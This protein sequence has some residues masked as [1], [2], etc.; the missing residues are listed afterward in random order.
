MLLLRVELPNVPG[1]LGRL[2]SAIGAAGGDIEAIEIVEKRLDGTDVET[3]HAMT[4]HKSQGSQAAEVTVL[5][6]PDDSRLLTRELLYT[7]LTRAEQKV[8]LV[9]TPDAVRLAVARPAQR[10]SGLAARLAHG[11]GNETRPS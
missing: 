7:A 10:A 4:V 2:A 1:S 6:P 11:P 3:M 8:T 5:L 9:A